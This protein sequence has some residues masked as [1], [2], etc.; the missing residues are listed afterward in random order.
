MPAPLEILIDEIPGHPDNINRASD[1]NYWLAL[2]GVRTPSF[3]LAMEKAGVPP[4]HGQA[5][6]NRRVARR[7]T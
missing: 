5:G 3:D 4:P 2:V 1:G 6:P 7:R